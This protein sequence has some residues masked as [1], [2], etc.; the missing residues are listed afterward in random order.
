[1]AMKYEVSRVQ[2]LTSKLQTII[3]ITAKTEDVLPYS[4]VYSLQPTHPILRHS[5][6]IRQ[7]KLRRAPGG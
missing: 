2:M 5:F 7:R 3:T 4:A 6:S 1:M